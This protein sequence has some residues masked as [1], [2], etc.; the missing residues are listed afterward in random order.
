MAIFWL[1][2][3]KIIIIKL[4]A[5]PNRYICCHFLLWGWLYWLQEY[6]LRQRIWAKV[7]N[8]WELD[9]NK[10]RIHWEQQKLPS[11]YINKGYNN[12]STHTKYPCLHWYFSHL[13][14]FIYISQVSPINL[15]VRL[16]KMDHYVPKIFPVPLG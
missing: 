16:W 12:I 6:K 7:K 10:V 14:L 4:W 9:G 5:V 8:Y 11:L 3:N 2:H 1:A 13:L 15:R